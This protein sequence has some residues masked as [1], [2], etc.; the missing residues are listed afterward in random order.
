[1]TARSPDGAVTIEDAKQKRQKIPLWMVAA[2]AARFELT[3]APTLDGQA[4]LLLVELCELHCDK[5]PVLEAH[6]QR[7]SEHETTLV[8]QPTAH[9]RI[10]VDA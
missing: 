8:D 7:E 9:K 4:L 5:L 3:N 2:D 10:D 6:P 1:M